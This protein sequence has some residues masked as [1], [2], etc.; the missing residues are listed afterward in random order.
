MKTK[1]IGYW[2]TTIVLV[3]AVLSGGVGQLGHLWGTLETVTL[4]GY[5]P[6]F[7]TI[8]GSWKVLG[9]IALLAP[10]FPR[11]KEWAYAGI[12]FEMTGA[13]A[14]HAARGDYGAHAYHL[15]VTFTFAGLTV[16]SWALRPRSRTLGVL[17]P[18][19]SAGPTDS[20]RQVA[21]AWTG[22]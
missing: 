11:L 18:A 9:A 12:F 14:S 1:A 7:L 4:L 6:Y 10:G 17:F 16:A 13:A 15:I 3:F 21:G 19:R 5:P 2:A 8:L 20:A 22:S